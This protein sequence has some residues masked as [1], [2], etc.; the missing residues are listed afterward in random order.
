MVSRQREITYMREQTSHMEIRY[1]KAVIKVTKLS[2][3][4]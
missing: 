2:A 3:V 4:M 1:Q